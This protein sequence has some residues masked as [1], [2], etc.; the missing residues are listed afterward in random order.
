MPDQGNATSGVFDQLV[1]SHFHLYCVYIES[2]CRIKEKKI[3]MLPKEKKRLLNTFHMTRCFPIC[4][5]N[6]HWF[7]IKEQPCHVGCMSTSKQ[8]TQ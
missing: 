2:F 6:C 4:A 8:D 1:C 3:Q 5:A 7:G